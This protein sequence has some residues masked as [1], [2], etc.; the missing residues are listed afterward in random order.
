MFFLNAHRIGVSV[1]LSMMSVGFQAVFAGSF[2]L[3]ILK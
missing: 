2:Y 3:S 1:Y